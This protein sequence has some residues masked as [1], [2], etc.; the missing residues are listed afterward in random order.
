M[1]VKAFIYPFQAIL[2]ISNDLSYPKEISRGVRS[3][4]PG[5]SENMY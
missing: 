2:L 1:N 5:K 4:A 3:S